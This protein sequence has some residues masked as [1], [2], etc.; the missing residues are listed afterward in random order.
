[1]KLNVTSMNEF[2][3]KNGKPGDAFISFCFTFIGFIILP[4]SI[5]SLIAGIGEAAIASG[6]PYMDPD[7]IRNMSANYW[8]YTRRFISLSGPLIIASIPLGFY[9]RGSYAKIPFA[10]FFSFYMALV[11]LIF[12]N[13]GVMESS[14]PGPG[15]SGR[16]V[17]ETV[18]LKMDVTPIIY[19]A[20]MISIARG[21]L[22]FAEFAAYRKEYL[23]WLDERERNASAEKAKE[24]VVEV[25][26]SKEPQAKT[27]DKSDGTEGGPSDDSDGD[28]DGD[29][30]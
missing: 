11:L 29:S 14:V 19:I 13:G 9:P 7:Q 28:S 24:E 15:G 17:L 10:L 2:S 20:I 25:P 1:M 3:W 26:V 12:V 16:I 21:F 8:A 30:D 22:S 4:L 23:E 5:Y 27:E 6:N 18:N